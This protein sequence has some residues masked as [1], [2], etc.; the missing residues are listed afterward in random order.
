MR[1]L[2]GLLAAGAL[3]AACSSDGDDEKGL[4]GLGTPQFAPDAGAQGAT[5]T[6]PAGVEG[7]PGTSSPTSAPAGGESAETT[8]TTV[9]GSAPAEPREQV[10]FDDPV[11]DAIGG[12]DDD[13]PAWA[14][15]AGATLLRQGNAYRLTVRLGDTAPTAA[16]GAETMNVATF[17]DVDGD[18][19]IDHEL[20]VNLG[21]GGWGPTWWTGDRAAPGEASN[22][23]V[24]VEGNE[25]QLL[26]PDVML[27]QPERLRFS[28]A[29][30][31]GALDVI[32][33]DFAHRDDAPDDDEAVSFPS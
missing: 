16:P 32:G 21:D 30:E 15:L 14:D 31:Y 7:G 4:D 25:L 22:V 6:Q 10:S 27:D 28:V 12:L 11:G 8:T 13:P 23:T 20:W 1:R 33:S 29:S 26:F 24:E 2:V 9:A 5:S 19:G 18:G 17:F 3:V